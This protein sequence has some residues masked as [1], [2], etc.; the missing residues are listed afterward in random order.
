MEKRLTRLSGKSYNPQ[1]Q[2]SRKFVDLTFGHCY[3]FMCSFM[4]R[5]GP[6]AEFGEP[7]EADPT[8]RGRPIKAP[9]PKP[10]A[11]FNADP[12]MAARLG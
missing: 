5:T 11:P 12:A 1:T 8:L 10:V 9:K 2:V 4:P 7:A 6:F 3:D